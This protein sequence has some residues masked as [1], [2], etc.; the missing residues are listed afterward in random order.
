MSE[1]GL[2]VAKPRYQWRPVRVRFERKREASRTGLVGGR[3]FGLRKQTV[4][5]SGRW[6]G[7]W[8]RW[9]SSSEGVEGT[10]ESVW[11]SIIGLVEAENAE[12][13]YGLAN[14]PRGR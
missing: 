13:S 2:A 1:A 9:L 7:S 5:T 6:N 14:R 4:V 12:T 3:R 10:T 11:G 8:S